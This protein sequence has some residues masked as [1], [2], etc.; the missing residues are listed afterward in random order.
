MPAQQLKNFCFDIHLGDKTYEEQE[1][2]FLSLIKS[3]GIPKLVY[4]IMGRELGEDKKTPHVQ[5]YCMLESR[6][7]WS[8]LQ[9][10]LGNIHFVS[11]DGT[12]YQNYVYCSKE[13]NVVVEIGS[14]PVGKGGKSKVDYLEVIKHARSNDLATLE[15]E[16]PRIFFMNRG[17]IDKLRLEGPKPKW[18]EKKGLYLV[19]SP[20][21]GKS[22]FAHGFDE[23]SYSKSPTKWWCGYTN[24][25]TV[26]LDDLDKSN[27]KEV[28]WFL[29]TWMDGYGHSGENKFGGTWLAFETFIITS[30]Y[31]L[32]TLYGDDP[33]LIKA[34]QGRFKVLVVVSHE[35]SPE[36]MLEIICQ[37]PQNPME[38]KRFNNNNVLEEILN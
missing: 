35:V 16:F 6:I 23:D 15:S 27:C 12:P 28:S 7:S 11:A 25:K 37:D 4:C 3:E 8:K 29:K 26:I 13:N 1:Q 18:Q 14:R 19:G 32:E 36:G 10:L 5:G 30:N 31:R 33:M 34:L 9:R 20:R 17:A 21:C 22:R 24:Q 2:R 38:I